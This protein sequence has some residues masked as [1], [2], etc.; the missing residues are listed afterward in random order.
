MLFFRLKSP[1]NKTKKQ[2][3]EI[4]KHFSKTKKQSAKTKS[5]F[6]PNKDLYNQLFDKKLAR[7]DFS[8]RFP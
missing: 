7:C 8:N 6:E 2:F 5:Y 1:S 4:K 3:T